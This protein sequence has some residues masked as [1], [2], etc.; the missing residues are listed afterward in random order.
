MALNLEIVGKPIETEPFRYG[1]DQTM[2]YAL[3]IGAGPKELDFIYEKNLKV[4][5]TFAVVPFLAGIFGPFMNKLNVNLA[6]VLHGEQKIILQRPIPP[7]GTLQSTLWC[8]SVYDKGDKGAVINLRMETRNAEGDLLFE[9]LGKVFDRTAGNFGGER[10]PESEIHEPPARLPPDFSVT[11]VTSFNQAAIYRL[12]GDKNP[13]HIDPAFARRL[14]FDRPILHGLCTFGFAARAVL[15]ALCENDPDR[16]RSISGRFLNPVF[17]G[18]TLLTEAWEMDDGR[19]VLRT[20]NQE[21]KP[22]LGNAVAE[23]K[24]PVNM[25]AT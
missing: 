10:G 21:G 17:P 25:E 24:P 13:L 19:Y 6:G 3:G 8:E 23:I 20:S 11:Y 1:P 9:N 12:S 14:G 4:Y 15:E 18:D 5:P 2:L 16:L 22:V 7:S